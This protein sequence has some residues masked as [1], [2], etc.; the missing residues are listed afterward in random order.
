[1]AL[2]HAV[3]D[4]LEGGLTLVLTFSSERLLRSRAILSV[5][6]EDG[7]VAPGSFNEPS[8]PLFLGEGVETKLREGG[9]GLV[10]DFLA[11]VRGSLA[12]GLVERR[13]LRGD[14]RRVRR[15]RYGSSAAIVSTA[16]S[17]AVSHARGSPTQLSSPANNLSAAPHAVQRFRRATNRSV[18]VKKRLSDVSQRAL[19]DRI[20][21]RETRARAVESRVFSHWRN[22]SWAG[23]QPCFG[24][25][26]RTGARHTETGALW[27]HQTKE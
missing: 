24:D 3:L 14:D 10:R 25:R 18:G 23:G 19:Q 6:L 7:G 8:Y 1:M 5:M 22:P 15:H 12:L 17:V 2:L 21:S 4:P 13:L 9:R 20:G 27:L 11:V 26:E 16:Q